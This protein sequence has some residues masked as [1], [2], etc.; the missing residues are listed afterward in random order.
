[1]LSLFNSGYKNVLVTFGTE[2]SFTTINTLIR[3]N[4]EQICIAF[5]NDENMAGIGGANRTQ[6]KLKKYF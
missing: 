1:M 5:D 2:I 4:P 6:S 3:C